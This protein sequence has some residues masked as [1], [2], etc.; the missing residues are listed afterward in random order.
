[1]RSHSHY[2]LLSE[3]YSKA[4]S[5][6]SITAYTLQIQILIFEWDSFSTSWFI[7]LFFFSFIFYIYFRKVH[8]CCCK[9]MRKIEL[10]LKMLYR[11]PFNISNSALIYFESS[12][13]RQHYKMLFSCRLQIMLIYRIHYS[14]SNAL[15]WLIVSLFLYRLKEYL[16]YCICSLFGRIINIRT[17]YE[18]EL[19]MIP[20]FRFIFNVAQRESETFY[21]LFSKM[22]IAGI[23]VVCSQLFAITAL[24]FFQFL[25]HTLFVHRRWL[26][27]FFEW[28]KI[29]KK[30]G[31]FRL[32]WF[33]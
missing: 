9:I 13:L 1:M 12:S 24:L 7:L 33:T 14:A 4:F 25:S 28:K 8:C 19:Q 31:I 29:T 27:D 5:I 32:T 20:S 10:K 11:T 22:L 30:N 15:V 18:I 2:Y 16:W 23:K 17:K 26:K 6:C 21:R 3:P